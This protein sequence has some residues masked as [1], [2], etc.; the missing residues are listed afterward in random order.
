[1]PLSSYTATLEIRAEH[2]D[3]ARLFSAFDNEDT[4]TLSLTLS[5]SLGALTPTLELYDADSHTQV[6]R[7]PFSWQSTDYHTELYR[8]VLPLDRLIGL[9]YA[10]VLF[11]SAE[12]QLRLSYDE[13]SYAERLSRADE[14]YEPIGLTVYEASYQTPDWFKGGVL[15]QIFVDRFH[16]GSHPV[17][18]RSDAKLNPD[19]E[20]GIPEYP[21]YRGAPFQNNTFFGGTLWGIAEKL[22]YFSDLGITALY[23]SPIFKAFSNHKYDTADY[24]EIDEMFG[25]EEAFDHLL[26]EATARGIRII[27]DGVFNHTGDDSRYFNKYGKFDDVGA[28]QSKSSPYFTWYDFESFPDKYRSW[29]GIDILPSLN[30]RHPDYRRFVAGEYGVVRHYLNK[31]ISGWRLD[32][33]DELSD[34][35]LR[36]IRR[37]AREEKRDALILGE[38]WEDASNKIAYGKLRRY[39]WGN[40]LDGVMNYPVGNRIADY[41]LTGN[42]RPLFA[43]LKRLYSHYPK[44]SSDANMNLLGTH[45]TERILT[46]LSGVQENARSEEELSLAR[47]TQRQYSEAKERLKAAWLLLSTVPGVPTVFYGDEAGNGGKQKPRRLQSLLGFTVLSLR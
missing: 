4:L 7:Y 22:D 11:D 19:W 14:P 36:D 15:Y 34:E 21:P 3:H 29:W 9:Y 39:F 27:L 35:L 6:L 31:G 24:F 16:K 42:A 26:K 33:A 8:L 40:Q 47:L 13:L 20:N 41:L 46:K 37:G 30:T 18:L 28:Y 5:R 10:S 17:P 38:V 44:I 25:G 23:L 1:M 2:T 32:V 45:D 43:T 12:G